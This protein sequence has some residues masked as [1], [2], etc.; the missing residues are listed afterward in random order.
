MLTAD[1]V[2]Q[3]N[4]QVESVVAVVDRRDFVSDLVAGD[5]NIEVSS[6]S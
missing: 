2:P 5:R 3:A 4:R 6:P 1:K